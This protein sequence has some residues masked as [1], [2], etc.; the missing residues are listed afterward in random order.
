MMLSTKD[1]FE[2]AQLAEASYA[3]FTV[4]VG[5]YDEALEDKDFSAIQADTLLQSWSVI[6]HQPN[7]DSGYSS[8]LFKSTDPGGGYVLA[9]RGTEWPDYDDLLSADGDIVGDGLATKQIV[10]T[11][12]EW[13]RISAASGAAYSAARLAYLTAESAAYADA[14]VKLSSADPVVRALAQ[15]AIDAFKARTDIVFDGLAA[16]TIEFA[17]ST[18][19]FS[20][21]RATGLG[22]AEDIAAKGLTVTGHSLGGHLATAF[23][24]LFPATGAA[25][26][27]VNGAGYPTGSTPGLSGMAF[28]NIDNLFA[29]LGGVSGFDTSRIINAYGED[30]DRKSVV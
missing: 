13:Q 9:F 23:A 26:L 14:T 25:A 10:D 28:T 1:F 3:N 17:S 2:L 6:T 11:Y 21:A 20:D 22:L 8:T 12:N 27:T 4:P 5:N 29:L 16:Y 7:T 24:R 30:I 19:L 18:T 15:S